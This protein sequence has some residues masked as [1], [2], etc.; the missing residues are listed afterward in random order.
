MNSNQ[1]KV[2]KVLA[3]VKDKVFFRELSKMSGVSIGGTQQILKDYS[4]YIDRETKGRQVYYSLK[5]N[6]ETIYLKRNIEI[7]TSQKFISENKLFEDFFDYFVK[8]NIPCV[9]FGGFAKKRY[10]KNSDID[11][12]VLSSVKIPEHLCPAKIHAIRLSKSQFE[13]AVRKKE[14]LIKEIIKNHVIVE[15]FDYFTGWLN[16]QN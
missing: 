10:S 11:I 7:M 8:R 14:T 4:N 15:G 1:Y 5:N 3:D 12:L 2:L 13:K 9:I 6:V 16:E